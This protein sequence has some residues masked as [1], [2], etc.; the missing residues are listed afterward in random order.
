M[1]YL[2]VLEIDASRFESEVTYQ[3]YA[4]DLLFMQNS[5]K[6]MF[7]MQNNYASETFRDDDNSCKVVNA[8]RFRA[9]APIYDV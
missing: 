8:V 6:R 7:F 9:E 5:Y 1:A 4:K 3:I 2:S